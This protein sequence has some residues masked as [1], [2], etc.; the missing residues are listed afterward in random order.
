[1]ANNGNSELKF[2]IINWGDHM[3]SEG[4]EGKCGGLSGREGRGKIRPTAANRRNRMGG[5]DAASF[6]RVNKG[7]VG[8]VLLVP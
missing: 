2:N 6:A 8:K 3:E 7:A 5:K 4:V 1:V